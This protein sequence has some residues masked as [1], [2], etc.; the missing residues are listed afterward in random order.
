[1]W[2][3]T[4]NERAILI[5]AKQISHDTVHTGLHVAF[6]GEGPLRMEPVEKKGG[7]GGGVMGCGAYIIT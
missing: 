4:G 3:P 5:V 7:P 6:Q 1:V 2:Y